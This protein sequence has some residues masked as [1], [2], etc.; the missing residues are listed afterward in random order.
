MDRHLIKLSETDGEGLRERE[1]GSRRSVRNLCLL[2]GR[3]G[4]IEVCPHSASML[5]Y[6]SFDESGSDGVEKG[7]DPSQ[8]CWLSSGA[9]FAVRNLILPVLERL[10]PPPGSFGR[11][12]VCVCV[13]V[14]QKR[15][16]KLCR[17]RVLLLMFSISIYMQPHPHLCE[18][19]GVPQIFFPPAPKQP[20]GSSPGVGTEIKKPI[21]N[22]SK[23]FLLC[24][25][26]STSF[27]YFGP[28]ACA[29]PGP[30]FG[31]EEARIRR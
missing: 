15:R 28:Q 14:Q 20:R 24:Y 31:P 5:D 18:A 30:N 8:C 1:G 7:S 26:H 11:V 2:P 4:D 16:N 17:C 19:R 21:F 27:L 9:R 13:F 6:R 29:P 10:R 22:A 12:C 23:L 3:L 25:R